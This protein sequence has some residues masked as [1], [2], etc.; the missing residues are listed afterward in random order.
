[1]VA[2]AS[3]PSDTDGA[4][5]VGVREVDGGAPALRFFVVVVLYRMDLASSPT[6]ASLVAAAGALERATVLIWDN[7]PTPQDASELA[8]FERLAAWRV[9]YVHA[10]EN[11][12]L[13]VAYGSAIARARAHD[14]V[15]FLDQDSGVPTE[16]FDQVRAACHAHPEC[17]VFLPIVESHGRIVSPG[18]YRWV[19][20]RYWP[21]ARYGLVPS[22]GL[23]AIN[24]GMAVRRT[25]LAEEFPGYDA[26]LRFYGVDTAFMLDHAR[27]RRHACVMACVVRHASALL[28]TDAPA[29]DRLRRHAGLFE[30]WVLVH[31]AS[32]V[33][34]VLVRLYVLYVGLREAVRSRDLRFVAAAGAAALGRRG[35]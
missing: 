28:D 33:R 26:R 12:G 6:I 18:S 15:V 16:Y 22:V 23:T 19:K 30:S 5:R 31:E 2:D 4:V 25:Y 10:P 20:G 9:E 14:V 29:A 7:G 24:S 8:R 1:M 32:F 34:S 27:R 11:A 21:T 3:H 35:A 17:A 13:P